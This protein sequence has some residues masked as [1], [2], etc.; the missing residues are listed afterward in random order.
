MNLKQRLEEPRAEAKVKG[1]KLG[2]ILALSS[3]TRDLDVVIY[4]D[5]FPI[6]RSM[7]MNTFHEQL[8]C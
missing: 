8:R 7:G 3:F 2:S 5:L 1:W 4:D 6:V